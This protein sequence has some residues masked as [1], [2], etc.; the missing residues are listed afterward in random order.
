[1]GLICC[2]ASSLNMRPR[3]SSLQLSTPLV[4]QKLMGTSWVSSPSRVCLRAVAKAW[5]RAQIAM[6]QGLKEGRFANTRWPKQRMS[7]GLDTRRHCSEGGHWVT[8]PAVFLALA[9]ITTTQRMLRAVAGGGW[10]GVAEDDGN[11]TR[12]LTIGYQWL[13]VIGELSQGA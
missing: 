9:A 6:C 4:S 10:L 12:P 1:M 7:M 3:F 13:Q 5:C 2:W 8:L 11:G